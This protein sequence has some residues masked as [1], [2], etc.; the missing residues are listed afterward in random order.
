MR[1]TGIVVKG[2]SGDPETAQIQIGH[3][4]T[5]LG[6]LK[7]Q[8]Q[9]A[10]LAVGARHVLLPDGTHMHVQVMGGV[11]RVNIATPVSQPVSVVQPV[12]QQPVFHE[13]HV[14]ARFPNPPP[15]PHNGRIAIGVGNVPGLAVN[16]PAAYN[17]QVISDPTNNQWFDISGQS[18][19]T[20]WQGLQDG[21]VG[22]LPTYVQ[23]SMIALVD[24][25]GNVY[26]DNQPRS[27]TATY[28]ANGQVGATVTD[29]QT[30]INTFGN[31]FGN[32]GVIEFQS[33]LVGDTLI[34]FEG[35]GNVPGG[36]TGSQ[37]LGDAP[38][39]GYVKQKAT[40]IALMKLGGVL[41]IIWTGTAYQMTVNG[42]LVINNGAPTA[43]YNNVDVTNG[44]DLV[45]AYSCD[46]ATYAANPTQFYSTLS[47]GATPY[48]GL[49]FPS[50]DPWVF[51]QAAPMPPGT[52]SG[53]GTSTFTDAGGN[54]IS[55]PCSAS[56]TLTL[57]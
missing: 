20:T 47:F 53:S 36:V 52:V 3:A 48:P 22:G 44:F 31:K 15:P 8:M 14:R 57:I 46:A 27:W 19:P 24:F 56:I 4:R 16:T 41:D 10:G 9:F 26:L 11:S 51:N 12:I 37:M 17:G 18:D 54:T 43:D 25:D 28:V 13:P 1:D 55:V 29:A 45:A 33:G 42:V 7:N 23:T 50:S 2:L 5:Q 32:A 49:A 34:K 35:K 21:T 38:V 30:L 6:I 39:V 40:S